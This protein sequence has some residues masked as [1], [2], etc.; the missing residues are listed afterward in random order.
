MVKGRRKNSGRDQVT[1]KSASPRKSRPP[2][3]STQNKAAR[4]PA[5]HQSAT[6][7]KDNI[8]LYGLHAVSAA[9]ANRERHIGEVFVTQN[10][11]DRLAKALDGARV[12]A[13]VGADAN[14]NIDFTEVPPDYIT[15]LTGPNAVHQGVAL[16]TKPLE[17]KEIYDIEHSRLIV[18]LDQLTDPHNVGAIIRSAVALGAGAILTTVRNSPLETGLLAKT[19]SGGLE[20]IDLVHVPNL[21]QALVHLKKSGFVAIGLDSEGDADFAD[22][23][24]GD[25][26]ALVLGAEGSGLRRLTKERCDVLARLD[27]PGPIKSLNVSNAAALSLYLAARHLKL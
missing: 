25:K 18:V 14:K 26:I 19:A 1:D 23:I 11:A 22:A 5:H 13:R 15:G 2:N 12:G 6:L 10:S 16:V 3:S 27:M 7:N 21:A 8:I 20:L 4:K 24:F 9:L 17:P